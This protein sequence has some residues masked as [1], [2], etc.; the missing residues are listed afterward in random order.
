MARQTSLHG[1]VEGMA[2]EVRDAVGNVAR[3]PVRVAGDAGVLN[4]DVLARGERE[5]GSDLHVG[6]HARDH[7]ALH[8]AVR[9]EARGS[10]VDHVVDVLF[11]AP[12]VVA[13]RG[14]A[15]RPPPRVAY[16]V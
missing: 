13:G 15:A 6:V 14:G 12:S 7:V 4:Q 2:G 9:A 11:G 10:V 3:V 5:G 1:W 16:W 8:G